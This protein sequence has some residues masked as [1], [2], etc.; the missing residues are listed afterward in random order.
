ML[1]VTC[2][3]NDFLSPLPNHHMNWSSTCAQYMYKDVV[4]AW[5][6]IE[7]INGGIVHPDLNAHNR[8]GHAHCM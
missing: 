7:G 2:C 1:Q 3:V 4:S 6:H 5:N 8:S